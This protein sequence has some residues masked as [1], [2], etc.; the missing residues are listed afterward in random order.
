MEAGVGGG[1]DSYDFF[2]FFATGRFSLYSASSDNVSELAEIRKCDNIYLQ[3]GNSISKGYFD[4]SKGEKQTTAINS[5]VAPGI[6]FFGGW[7][8]QNSTKTCFTCNFLYFC[9]T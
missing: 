6:F 4:R 8:V 3:F 2:L 9:T 7:G 1:Y 5:W